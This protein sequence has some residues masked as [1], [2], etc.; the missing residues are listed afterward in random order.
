MSDLT[1]ELLEQYMTMTD[2]DDNFAAGDMDDLLLGGN[3]FSGDQIEDEKSYEEWLKYY[4]MEDD[5]ED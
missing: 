2:F 1:L 4:G 5:E 3:I